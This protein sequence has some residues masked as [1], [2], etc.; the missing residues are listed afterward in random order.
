MTKVA[1]TSG[2]NRKFLFGPAAISVGDKVY[3][4]LGSGDR[5][6]PLITNYPYVTP[7]T[8]RFYTFIDTF[9]NT[10][11]DLDGL[12][13]GH[14]HLDVVDVVGVHDRAAALER[15]VDGHVG[16]RRVLVRLALEHVAAAGPGADGIRDVASRVERAAR[17]RGLDRDGR[18]GGN[19]LGRQQRGASLH[20]LDKRRP[21]G[22]PPLD[23]RGLVH[24][25][26]G[27]IGAVEIADAVV[28]LGEQM[29]APIAV[30][31]RGR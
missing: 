8:N 18:P 10:D 1:H 21:V 16:H 5:E 22:K 26:I 6:R 29:R 11:V 4:A 31:G 3:L 9:T 7:I 25:H 23:K 24:L 15:Q 17:L 12:A 14:V 2:A 27:R 28:E 19:P 20:F 30:D 13:L